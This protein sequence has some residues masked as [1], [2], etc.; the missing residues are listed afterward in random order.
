MSIFTSLA[1]ARGSLFTVLGWTPG[2]RDLLGG[3]HL[4]CGCLTGTYRS[5]RGTP[6]TVVDARGGSCAN[7]RHRVNAVL[8]TSE[9]PSCAAGEAPE[10]VHEPV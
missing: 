4:A 8:W 2:V 5:W 9:M 1:P 7:E 6:M 10:S 3:Q